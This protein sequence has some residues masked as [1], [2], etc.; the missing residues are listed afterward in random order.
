MGKIGLIIG[1]VIALLVVFI[2]GGSF[3]TVDEGERAVVVSQG[4]V[5]GVAGP[6]FHWKKPFLDEAHVISVRTQAAEF[7]DEPV[8]TGDQQ[9]ANVTFSV[10]Y[11]AIASDAEISKIY[12]DY[13]TIDGLESK[14]LRRQ[15]REQIKNVF[16]RYSAANAIRERSKLNNDVSAAIANL[17]NGVIKIE[18]LNIENIDFSDAVEAAAEQRAQQEML[19]N[20]KEQQRLVAEKEAAIA[21]IQAQAEADSQLAVAKAKADAVKLQGDAEASA[22]KAKS[23]ALAQ[24]PNLVELT[25]AERWDG[26]LPTSFIPGSATPFLSIK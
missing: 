13:Q 14:I 11:A 25:K 7:K 21:V 18:G 20:T 12:R 17:G 1:G 26:K 6:G 19:V 16:G 2:L 15:V 23:D 3:Y 9:T 22:I 8:F 10:N 4:K 24:S 5:A